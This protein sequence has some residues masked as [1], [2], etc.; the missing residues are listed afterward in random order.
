VRY[1]RQRIESAVSHEIEHGGKVSPFGPTHIWEGIINS[2]LL[3]TGVIPAGTVTA[4]D[5]KGQL[6]LVEVV[7]TKIQSRNT[8]EDDAT[9]FPRHVRSVLHGIVAVSR[10][11]QEDDIGTDAR[12]SFSDRRREIGLIISE[13]RGCSKLLGQR[14]SLSGTVDADHFAADS[15]CELHG[16]EPDWSQAVNHG[17]LAERRVGET[18]TFERDGS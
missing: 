6:L 16:E 2:L 12:G 10:E 15:A 17:C 18:E 13:K 9:P 1:Q 3:V 5:L 8:D 4:R 11:R 14:A 7:A